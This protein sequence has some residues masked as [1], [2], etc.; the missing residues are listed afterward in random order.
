[1]FYRGAQAAFVVY[2]I[3]NAATLQR[4]RKWIEELHKA[5]P[6]NE[7]LIGLIGN[8]SDRGSHREVY[9]KEA[10]ELAR[11]FSDI[12]FY[13]E[14]SAKVSSRKR[15][16]STNR[17]FTFSHFFFSQESDSWDKVHKLNTC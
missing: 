4:A 7:L 17:L 12:L 10:S 16:S 1:M 2:D 11:E 5:L 6:L 13:K 15:S 3:T 14:I 9:Q 8:K